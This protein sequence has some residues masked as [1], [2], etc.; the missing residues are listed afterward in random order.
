MNNGCARYVW[1]YDLIQEQVD[2]MPEGR[3]ENGPLKLVLIER[4][5]QLAGTQRQVST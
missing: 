2:A 1:D 5:H 4:V 3:Y